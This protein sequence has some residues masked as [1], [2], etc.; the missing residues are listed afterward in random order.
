MSAAQAR[1]GR[2]GILGTLGE[3]GFAT[4]Y[5]AWDP[6]LAR[7]VALKVLLPHLAADPAFRHQFIAEARALA[8]LHHANIVTVYSVDEAEGRPFFTME[9]IEGRTLTELLAGGRRAPL[10]EVV[11]M[12]R[13]LASAVDYFHAAGIVHGDIKAAN[14]M[15]DGAGRVVVMDFGIARM[16]DEG[17]PTRMLADGGTS[18]RGPLTAG[19]ASAHR[20]GA[21]GNMGTPETMAPEQIR[22]EPAR[23]PADVYAL[24]VLAY[25]LLAGHLPHGGAT[26]HI[27]HLKTAEPA[28][29]LRAL[30][31]DL[32]EAV[33]AAVDA[34]LDRDPG[35]RPASAGRFAGMLAAAAAPYLAAPPRDTTETAVFHSAP[36]GGWGRAVLV[37]GL[38]GLVLALTIG[39][40]LAI[41]RVLPERGAPARA[42]VA[43]GRGP[44]V[45]PSP[46]PVVVTAVPLAGT[47][48]VSIPP[49]ALTPAHVVLPTAPARAIPLP[50]GV[51]ATE[52]AI[53]E[54]L[55][56]NGPVFIDAMRALDASGLGASFADDAFTYYVDAIAA[57][58][59]A[60]QYEDAELVTISLRELRQEGA[61][62]A[63]VRTTERWRSTV[64]ETASGKKLQ[65]TETVYDEEYHLVRRGG[66][67]LITNLTFT[68]VSEAPY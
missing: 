21:L 38:A 50:V 52:Q 1:F 63:S 60:G 24:G 19:T 31:P 22:G 54:A 6:S 56:R 41:V 65:G 40:T 57:L 33:C 48:A 59:A 32:P 5:R 58:K 11:A 23:P 64:R 13:D 34:A 2:Y 66:R 49:A 7:E 46:S 67:W 17:G 68:T 51:D 28:P 9:L 36:R 16:L 35:R 14:V 44:A 26:E 20:A 27:L 45:T 42:D 37:A 8:R 61:D 4:V 43:P 12:L 30:R 39:V 3:G 55:N 25:Q 47:R 53:V 62:R 10:D 29:S 18:G 15:V